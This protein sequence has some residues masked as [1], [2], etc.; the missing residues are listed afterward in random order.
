[1]KITPFVLAAALLAVATAS[2][3]AAASSDRQPRPPLPAGCMPFDDIRPG[4]RAV[5][6]TVFQGTTLDSFA[7]EILGVVR[8]FTPG[9]G[10]IL[11]RASG[12]SVERVG[13]AQGMSGSPIFVDGKLIGALAYGWSFSREPVTGITPIEQMLDLLALDRLPP[14]AGTERPS[15]TPPARRART[16]AP[17][18]ARAPA[19]IATPVSAAGLGPEALAY[20][21]EHLRG[22]GFALLPGG[23][24]PSAAA[25]APGGGDGSAAD[26]L[27][28]GG[29][30]GIILARGDAT[31]AGFGTVTYVDGDRVLGLGHPLFHA[32][33]TDLPLTTG[34]VH[35]VIPL[36][37]ASFKWASPGRSVGLLSGD[38]SAGV[39]G[40]LGREADLLPL[41]VTVERERSG[42]RHF[43]F[44]VVRDP[45]LAPF[46]AAVLSMNSALAGEALN[47]ECLVELEMEVAAAGRPRLRLRDR[48]ASGSPP[49]ALGQGVYAPLAALLENPFETLRV[50]SLRVKARVRE[51]DHWAWIEEARL[52]PAVA[53]PGDTLTV[54][55]WL[56]S[57]RGE[58]RRERARIALPSSLADGT[59]SLRVCDADSAEAWERS[60]MP[61]AFAPRDLAHLMQLLGAGRAHDQVYFQLIRRAEGR[62]V[63]G[64]EYPALPRSVLDVMKANDDSPRL[65]GL[66]AE[67]LAEVAL[68]AGVQVVGSDELQLT[69]SR[70][71]AGVRPP[72]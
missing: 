62:L 3:A 10:L 19:P 61:Q 72:R 30:M 27:R 7:L 12:D 40:W 48:I 47:E 70:R 21:D 66:P 31:I 67:I 37:S 13:I 15:G 9:G 2:P 55:V 39:S 16:I 25:A 6:R 49:Q 50:D 35:T 28:P 56:R 5:G 54:D 24:S 4:M 22:H 26:S 59:L 14:R 57:Y 20:L 51:G 32:G 45:E 8:D 18:D 69:V 36:S 68:P 34:F 53:R 46:L 41:E 17:R 29:T 44:E 23:G 52:A 38:R 58:S 42:A 65:R 43:R 64:R 33:A 63:N 60:V 71:P 1:M 11:A